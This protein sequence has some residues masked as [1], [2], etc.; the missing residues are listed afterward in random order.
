[1]V[2]TPLDARGNIDNH[3]FISGVIGTSKT[4]I[5]E[6]EITK[7]NCISIRFGCSESRKE[8]R[9]KSMGQRGTLQDFQLLKE[10][11]KKEGFFFFGRNIA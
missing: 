9:K 2:H 6:L 5:P 8:Q 11:L 1:M 4:P 7:N 3:A 10:E